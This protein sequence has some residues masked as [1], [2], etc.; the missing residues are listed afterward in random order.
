M[1]RSAA[2]GHEERRATDDG[3][4]P[5]AR[6]QRGGHSALMLRDV[7][8]I[9]LVG[10]ALICAAASIYVVYNI[11]RFKQLYDWQFLN[12]PNSQNGTQPSLA[13]PR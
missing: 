1:N 13:P 7:R 10:C 11:E 5:S 6:A 2:W 3:R 12:Q 9:V 8:D 4:R